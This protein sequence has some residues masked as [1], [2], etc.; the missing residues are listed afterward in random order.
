MSLTRRYQPPH[1]PD[2][3]CVFALDF[4]A[5]IPRGA[6]ITRASLDIFTNTNPP[7]EA[8]ADWTQDAVAWEGR[9]VYCGL[10]GGT[11]GVDYRLVWTAVDS[12]G[13]TWPRTTLVLCSD[14]S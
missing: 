13:N 8:S 3:T 10:S 4:G 6:N 12:L 11:A 1:P 14:T 9:S 2:E 5:L 7:Q